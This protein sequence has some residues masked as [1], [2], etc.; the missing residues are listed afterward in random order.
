MNIFDSMR[1]MDATLESLFTHR[2]KSV[3][4]VEEDEDLLHISIGD[5][6]LTLTEEEANEVADKISFILIDRGVRE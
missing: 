6:G 5:D 3:V 2:P 4:T 1:H